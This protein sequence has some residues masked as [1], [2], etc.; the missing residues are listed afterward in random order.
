MVLEKR[1]TGPRIA[2]GFC[3]CPI[4]KSKIIHHSLKKLLDP[5]ES[6]YEDVKKKALM[7]LEYEGLSK[8]EAVATKGARFFNDP[9][10][11]GFKIKTS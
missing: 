10:R 8:C 11:T 4:C 5:I 9:V 1:W 7:R 2:F 3:N 6:L